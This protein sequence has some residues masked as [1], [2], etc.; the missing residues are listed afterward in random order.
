VRSPLTVLL[1]V[2][3][4]VGLPCATTLDPR[5]QAAQLPDPEAFMSRVRST[6]RLDPDLQ[7]AFTFVERRREV[8]IGGLGKVSV[9]PLRTFEVFPSPDP[10]ATYKRLIAID[11]QPL[12]PAELRRRDL[13]HQQDVENEAR[14]RSQET[15]AQQARRVER[16]ERDR[17]HTLAMLDDAFNV[18]RPVLLSRETIDGVPTIAVDLTPRAN[19]RVTTR[20]GNWMKSFEGRAWFVEEDLQLVRLDFR[21]VDDVSIGWGLV[22]RLYEGSRIVVERRP[23][24]RLWLPSRLTFDATGRTLLFRPFDLNVVTEYWDYKMK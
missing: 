13:E 22:G 20:E 7:K 9:G 8:K 11:D 10:G 2:I 18:F 3:L 15:S 12:D 5:T 16:I 24:G 19:A 4:S 6:V 17:R 23:V 21:A 14:K 1:A